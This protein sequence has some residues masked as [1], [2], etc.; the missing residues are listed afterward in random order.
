MDAGK[1]EGHPKRIFRGAAMA[2]PQRAG[3]Q[4]EVKAPAVAIRKS[5]SPDFIICLEDGKRFKSLRSHLLW[6]TH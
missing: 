2:E 4:I 1:N 3:P 5:N 6:L